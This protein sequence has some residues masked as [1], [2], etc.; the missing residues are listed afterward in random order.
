MTFAGGRKLSRI[1]R[2]SHAN[3][4]EST[5]APEVKAILERIEAQQKKLPIADLVATVSN[6]DRRL[7][8][9]EAQLQSFQQ[10]QSHRS[11]AP[12][13]IRR[14]QIRERRIPRTSAQAA[15]V[16]PP[17]EVID[18]ARDITSQRRA[19]R[20][21]RVRERRWMSPPRPPDPPTTSEYLSRSYRCARG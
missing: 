18:T 19:E 17:P 5:I 14:R 7:T 1:G 11:I 15:A 4:G 3:I 2:R 20:P 16:S 8:R 13:R 21:H 10:S 12:K 9:L 6:V